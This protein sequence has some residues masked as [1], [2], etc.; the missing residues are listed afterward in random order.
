MSC[1]VSLK[2]KDT[3]YIQYMQ[4]ITQS[5]SPG[6]VSLQTPRAISS[7]H[8]SSHMEPEGKWCATDLRSTLLVKALESP[9]CAYLTVR[10]MHSFSKIFCDCSKC[11]RE[12]VLSCP[13]FSLI[14]SAKESQCYREKWAE[15]SPFQGNCAEP[16]KWPTWSSGCI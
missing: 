8:C 16:C 10:R 2:I 6:L 5:F 14:V 4:S 13:I 15:F 9:G 11:M 1:E 3:W 12:L 7:S